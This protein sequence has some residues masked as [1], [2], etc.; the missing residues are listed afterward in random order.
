MQTNKDHIQHVNE[1][2]QT[3]TSRYGKALPNIVFVLGSGLGSFADNIDDPCTIDYKDIPHFP[4]STVV[5]H[6]GQLVIGH[7][8]NTPCIVMKGRSHFYEGY[9]TQQIT[10][11]LR[12]LLSLGVK[13]VVLTNA[14]GGIRK[15]LI[16]G[17]FMLIT[18]HINMCPENPLRGTN[19]ASWGQRF[20]DMSRAYDRTLRDLAYTSAEDCGVHLFEGVYANMPGPSYET[21]AEINMLRILGVDAVGMSTVMETIVANHMG[22]KVLGISCI[23]NSAASSKGTKLS[24]GDVTTTSQRVESSFVSLLSRIA[25]D[26]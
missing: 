17:T 18:D 4:T 20:P 12:A 7:C 19:N 9:S 22:A 21:P 1:A 16:P 10:L 5:G 2:A 11:P 15:N 24:H 23:T 3:I 26:L 13:T 25:K 8:S 14:A 6:A